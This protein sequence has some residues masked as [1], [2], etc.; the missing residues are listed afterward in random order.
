[1]SP[2]D[3]YDK[4]SLLRLAFTGLKTKNCKRWPSCLN[5]TRTRQST[6]SVRKG[7]EE[8][9][10]YIIA[11]GSVLI[12]QQ[13]SDEEG[14]RILRTGDKG[15]VIGEMAL[16]QSAPRSATVRTTSACTTLEMDKRDFETILSHS[17][18][19]ANNIIRITLDRI[20]ANDRMAVEDLQKTN[21]IL[22]QLDRNKLDFIQV[23]SHELRTP[24]TIIKGY[25]ELLDSF[26]EVNANAEVSDVLA[27]IN[28][29]ADRMHEVVNL[30]LD[31]T[32]MDAENLQIASVPVL[33]KQLVDS[34]AQDFEERCHP[35]E[36]RHHHKACGQYAQYLCRPGIDPESS[37][38][39]DHQCDQVHARWRPGNDQHMPDKNGWRHTC[40]R[41]YRQG[42]R[43][44]AG[45]GAPRIW[46]LKSSIR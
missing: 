42:Y 32:R 20:R 7:A 28:K 31:V 38:S 44:R 40:G 6:F 39:S 13:L 34:L 41:G 11:D 5:F 26:P 10:F 16:I 37:I 29:G 22:R 18:R 24:L 9:V 12:T 30:M 14:E 17:P 27:G 1:M 15:D 25:V 19:L 23:A 21:K 4:I 35:T 8:D 46:Y 43:Y 3:T 36:D 33:L 2:A 45:P